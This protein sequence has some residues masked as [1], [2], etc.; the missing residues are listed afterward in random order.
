MPSLHLFE[1]MDLPGLPESLRTTVREVLEI[2]LGEPPRSYYDWVVQALLHRAEQERLHTIVE[3][4][5]GTAPLSHRL[6]AVVK[7]TGR[8]LTVEVSDLYPDVPLYRSLEEQFP[9]VIRGR[10]QPLDF[11]Q[12]I[13]F[14]PGTLLALSGSFHHLPPEKRQAVLEC[15]AKQRV[16]IFEPL[17][18]NPISM[19]TSFGGLLPGLMAPLYYLRKRKGGHARRMFWCWLAPAAPLIIIWDGLVSCLRCWTESEWRQALERTSQGRPKRLGF[20][21]QALSFGVFW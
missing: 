19:F 15:L 9:G 2:C 4:G 11:S 20:F 7:E 16:A 8:A 14:P 17:Q 1:F 10:T 3:L 18:R 5:A 13:E 12:P 21:T 6:V